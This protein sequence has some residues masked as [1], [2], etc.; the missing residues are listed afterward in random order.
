MLWCDGLPGFGIGVCVALFMGC[1]LVAPVEMARLAHDA[2]IMAASSQD[3]GDVGVGEYP[4][5][6]WPGGGL[7]H[8]LSFWKS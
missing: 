1:H 2:G 3:E 5:L 6:G 8:L 4:D 7:T